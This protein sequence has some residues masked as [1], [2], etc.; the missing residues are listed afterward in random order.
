[1][2]RLLGRL[3]REARRER[4]VGGKI[5][6]IRQLADRLGVHHSYL[7]RIERGDDVCLK[8][9]RLMHLADLLGVDRYFMLAVAG[10]VPEKLREA[11][12]E[13]RDAF[14]MFIRC[15]LRDEDL[16]AEP[17]GVAAASRPPY[18]R[19]PYTDDAE[20][21]HGLVAAM[22]REGWIVS[23]MAQ[24]RMATQLSTCDLPF[25]DVD[26]RRGVV[27]TAGVR[28]LR[29]FPARRGAEGGVAL[30]H[31][32]RRTVTG[33]LGVMV[34]MLHRMRH[35]MGARVR[36]VDGFGMVVFDSNE[37]APLPEDAPDDTPEDAPEDA[38]AAVPEGATEGRPAPRIL[39]ERMAR[40]LNGTHESRQRHERALR[41]LAMSAH[42]FFPWDEME[43]F[44]YIILLPH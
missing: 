33:K 1:M 2:G 4:M 34:A 28:S 31:R 8:P 12:Y 39:F 42:A 41:K 29:V 19:I 17:D 21:L 7:S 22:T 13:H 43:A 23:R 26:L 20:L 9:E 11:I 25:C 27:A 36:V 37:D 38:P 15:V 10:I 16:P 40:R 35:A 32:S 3:V 14:G 24:D 5:L 18:W 30:V 6:S 44:S